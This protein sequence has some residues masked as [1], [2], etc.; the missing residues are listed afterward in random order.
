MTYHSV[1]GSRSNAWRVTSH[2][3]S[4]LTVSAVPARPSARSRWPRATRRPSKQMVERLAECLGVPPDEREDLLR[5]ARLGDAVS[6][7]ITFG[8]WLTQQRV[9]RD[10]TQ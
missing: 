6:G 10:R 3:K 4:W 2:R 1:D 5:M 7:E 9:A 8:R